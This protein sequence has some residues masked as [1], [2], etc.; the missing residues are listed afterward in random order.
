[1]TRWR[2]GWREEGREGGRR[3]C[4]LIL[5]RGTKEKNN[6]YSRKTRKEDEGKLKG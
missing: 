4:G 6:I 5:E 2:E 1:M 3:A